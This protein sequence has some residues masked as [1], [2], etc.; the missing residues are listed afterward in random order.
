MKNGDAVKYDDGKIDLT[1]IPW[2]FMS[3]HNSDYALIKPL[4]LWWTKRVDA[5]DVPQLMD[6]AYRSFGIDFVENLTAALNDSVHK[7]PAWN[8]YK[9]MSAHRLYAAACRH[10]LAF[11]RCEE[12][13]IESGLSHLS[14][15]ASY[16][17][18]IQRCID[19]RPEFPTGDAIASERADWSA[20]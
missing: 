5:L 13:D 15:L 11:T 1:L 2:E 8:W 7:Y 19:D 3:R 12:Q 10:Y 16:A 20:A 14:H 18:M 6:S 9:G 17:V 4:Y